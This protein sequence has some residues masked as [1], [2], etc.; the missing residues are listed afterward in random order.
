MVRPEAPGENATHDAAGEAAYR[1]FEIRVAC[2]SDRVSA[3]GVRVD[4]CVQTVHALVALHQ[5]SDLINHV[6]RSL[7]HNRAA[8]NRITSLFDVHLHKTLRCSIAATS[9]I[10]REVFAEGDIFDTT[11]IQVSGIQSD[12]CNFRCCER[13]PGNNEI[14]KLGVTEKESIANANPSHPVGCV[15]KLEVGAAVS[16]SVDQGIAYTAHQIVHF[17]SVSIRK[18]HVRSL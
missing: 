10:I 18:R 3:R 8:E 6:T 13:A 17:D 15:S 16:C 12:M 11:S 5:R 9:I 7:T 14:R 2:L 4:D 1:V